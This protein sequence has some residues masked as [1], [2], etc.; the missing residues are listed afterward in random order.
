MK[1]KVGKFYKIVFNIMGK[2][3]TFHC[4]IDEIDDIFI[5]FTDK[6]GK[7]LSYNKNLILSFEEVSEW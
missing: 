2:V 4:R 1:L 3:L 5:S 6:Y 7:Q